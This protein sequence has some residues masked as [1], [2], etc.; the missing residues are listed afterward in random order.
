[1]TDVAIFHADLYEAGSNFSSASI[2]LQSDITSLIGDDPGVEAPIGRNQLRAELNRR[3]DELHDAVFSHWEA[4]S[5][6]SSSAFAITSKYSLLDE[7]LSGE[8]T[9]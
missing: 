9:P 2:D 7:E 8:N 1:M 5:A 6:L 3:V 4:S